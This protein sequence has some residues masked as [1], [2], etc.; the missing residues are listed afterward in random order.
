MTRADISLS[1]RLVLKT[2]ALSVASSFMTGCWPYTRHPLAPPCQSAPSPA[3]SKLTIDAHCH[4][5]NGSDLDVKDF[6][7]KVAWNEK[8][9]MAPVSDAVAA[10]LEDLAW[11]TAPNGEQELAMLDKFKGCLSESARRSLIKHHHDARYVA[12]RKALLSTKALNSVKESGAQM[13][14]GPFGTTNAASRDNVLA[15]MHQRLQPKS[16]DAYLQLRDN[17]YSALHTQATQPE[18]LSPVNAS[19]QFSAAGSLDY[20]IENFQYRYGAMQDYL[21]TYSEKSGRNVDLMLASMVDYDWWISLGSGPATALPKQVQVMAKISVV[22][23]G[24]VHGFVPFDPL[25]EVAYWAGKTPARRAGAEAAAFSSLAIVKDAI[26][27]QGCVGVK[28]YPPMGFAAYGNAECGPEFWRRDWLPSWMIEPIPSKND[29]HLLPVGQ[30]LDDALSA[31]YTWCCD[32]E[33]PIMAHSNSSNGVVDEFKAL[34][35]P[36]YWRSAL[37]RWPNLRVS[38]GHLGGFSDPKNAGQSN[39]DPSLFIALMTEDSHKAGAK[40]YGDTAYFSEVLS[41]KSSLKDQI[42]YAYLKS[43]ILAKRLMYGTDWNLLINVGDIKDYL[44]DFITVLNA[45]D[46]ASGQVSE[47]FFGYN[48]TE[49]IGLRKDMPARK[50]LE[51]FYLRNGFDLQRNPPS[52]MYKLDSASILS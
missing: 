46:Q 25:R 8:G 42:L 49:W 40:A 31:L 32:N 34:A 24:Q 28:L 48:A 36:K 20:L 37:D 16:R 1:R 47:R 44:S 11:S 38:F 27:N 41:A 17:A 9:I 43:S 2:A 26:E 4:I 45:A 18:Y 51:S 19:T 30:R 35:G 13:L 50:R 7:N 33:V 15:E 5:F 14:S 22:S 21:A 52:W 39:S 12:A 3:S 6:F 29:N 23:Q 10:I